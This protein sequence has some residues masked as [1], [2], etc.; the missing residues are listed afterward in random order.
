MRC[1]FYS[2]HLLQMPFHYTHTHPLDAA[3]RQHQSRI[4]RWTRVMTFHK[5]ANKGQTKWLCEMQQLRKSTFIW[6][7]MRV[8]VL[9]P[10]KMSKFQT[11]AWVM[12][13]VDLWKSFV[14]H[15]QFR[16]LFQW[17]PPWHPPQFK[18][19]HQHLLGQLKVS[20]QMQHQQLWNQVQPTWEV[21]GYWHSYLHF[22]SWHSV[23][24][25]PVKKQI[26]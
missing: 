16:P 6:V 7:P 2:W 21:V 3:G 24:V 11:H 12:A 19:Q 9:L 4:T 25:K 23:D 15:F 10:C 5:E 26:Q 20:P 22:A 14:I 18:C 1:C 8:L 17:Q 13:R